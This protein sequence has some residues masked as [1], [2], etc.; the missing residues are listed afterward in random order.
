MELIK[1]EVGIFI[2]ML[3][4]KNFFLLKD[5]YEECENYFS[6][7]TKDVAMVLIEKQD[8]RVGF[9]ATKLSEYPPKSYKTKIMKSSIESIET[10]DIDNEVYKLILK[11]MSGL[12]T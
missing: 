11:E 2:T 5:K 7:D 12:I 1:T 8:G 9:G 6:A 4:G 10:L 3:N